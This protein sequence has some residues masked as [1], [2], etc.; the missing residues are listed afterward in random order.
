[1]KKYLVS[2]AFTDRV[3]GARAGILVDPGSFFSAI[4]QGLLWRNGEWL[5]VVSYMPFKTGESRWPVYPDAIIELMD[6]VR[7]G[8][9]RQKYVALCLLGQFNDSAAGVEKSLLEGPASDDNPGVAMAAR[10]CAARHNVTVTVGS[11]NDLVVD[12]ISGLTFAAIPG[13]ESF[14]RGSD[15][16]DPDRFADEDRPAQGVAIKAFHMATTEVTLDGF[17]SFV[18]D[19]AWG[20]RVEKT[21]L[22]SLR[23]QMAGIPQ[24]KTGQAAAGFISLNTARVY[25]EWLNTKAAGALPRRTYRLPTE[26]EWEYACRAGNPGRFCFGDNAD[27]ARYFAHCN[28]SGA[29]YHVVGERMPNAFGLFDVHG[30]VW[31][32]TSTRCPAEMAVPGAVKEPFVMKGGGGYAPAVRCRS[33]QRRW[34]AAEAVETYNGIRLVMEMNP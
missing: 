31:E 20:H 13:M 34:A 32:W 27:Y 22:E 6:G 9:T 8:G 21:A 33:A 7:N 2:E 19:R 17:L 1:V 30:G 26:D 4:D 5:D 29:S 12:E 25:C 28:G 3:V 10:W 11:S 16:V 24:A 15:A 18:N 14:R 23:T